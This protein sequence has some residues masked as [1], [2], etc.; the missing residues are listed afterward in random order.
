MSLITSTIASAR[1]D[2]ASHTAPIG[3]LQS[4]LETLAHDPCDRIEGTRPCEP[5]VNPGGVSVHCGVGCRG[6]PVS[7][8]DVA[9]DRII[10]GGTP[11]LGAS[12]H[13]ILDKGT[14][15][16]GVDREGHLAFMAHNWNA[17]F[18]VGPLAFARI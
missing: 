17:L 15:D 2:L 12:A 7:P 10:L 4:N 1:G 16:G 9:T 8:E 6:G 5:A 3:P 18:T 14:N 13:G 11:A